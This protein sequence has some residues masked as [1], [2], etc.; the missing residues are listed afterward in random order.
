[1]EGVAKVGRSG[2]ESIHRGIQAKYQRDV[3]EDRQRLDE[4]KTLA[5]ERGLHQA[6]IPLPENLQQKIFSHLK[7]KQIYSQPPP[8]E[9]I[10]QQLRDVEADPRWKSFATSPLLEKGKDTQPISAQGRAVH[11][12]VHRNFMD[13]LS[14]E[15]RPPREPEPEL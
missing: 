6:R 9:E 11:D 13:E 5:W 14:R 3:S 1:M 15:R 4:I 7:V 8:T 10:Q 12:L 2:R